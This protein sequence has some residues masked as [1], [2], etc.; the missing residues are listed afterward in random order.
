MN[1]L[2]TLLSSAIDYAGLFPP[3]NLGMQQAVEDYSAYLRSECS[4]MLGRFIVPI[5]RL[6]EF[7]NASCKLP[8]A[9][10][11]K[12][13]HLTALSGPRLD[14]SVSL[15]RAFNAKHAGE[16]STGAAI[17]TIELKASKPDEISK[18][19]GLPDSVVTY[20]E[21]PVD[22]NPEPLVETIRNIGARAKVRTGGILKNMFPKSA[23]IIRFM[24]ACV[25]AGVPFK[26]TAG[27]H[28]PIR[29]RYRLT[30]ERDSPSGMMYGFLNLLL[31][32]AF[33][34]TGMKEAEA[35]RLL[36]EENPDNFQIDEDGMSWMD[37]RL[38]LDDIRKARKTVAISFGSCSFTEPID[39]LKK[40]RLL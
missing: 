22:T 11:P 8:T 29:G 12:P 38:Q 4:W 31:T 5:T 15:I 32:A 19:N 30:Y 21:I 3:A 14:D 36:E 7:E 1:S 25:N 33:I 16:S 13:W 17:D 10:L 9:S 28:H 26:A 18:L 27:L 34:S 35:M 2:R 37:H 20:V 39:E 6:Q 24:I 23:D 40:L